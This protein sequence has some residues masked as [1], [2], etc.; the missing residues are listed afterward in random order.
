MPSK[1]I[2]TTSPAMAPKMGV[3]TANTLAVLYLLVVTLLSYGSALAPS[4]TFLPADLLLLRAPYKQHTAELSPGFHGV[5]RPATD[6]LFQFYPARK[7]LRDALHSGQVPLWNPYSL[8]GTPFAADDQSAVFYPI[9]WLFALIP[10]TMAFGWV[11]ALHTFLAGL[12]F[13]AWGRRLGWGHGAALSGAT[14]WMLSGVMVSW[15]MWQVVDSTLCWLPLALYFWEGYRERRRPAQAVGVSVA[16]GLCLLAGH[17][18]F[19]FFVWLT[20]FAYALYR[21]PLAPTMWTVAARTLW[22]FLLGAAL[23]FVQLAATADL[24]PR[25]VKRD[26]SLDEMLQTALPLKQLA[27]LVAPGLFGG[28][29]DDLLS[30]HFGAIRYD[31]GAMTVFG[32]PP[33]VGAVNLYE[34]TVY[35]GVAALVFAVCGMRLRDRGDLSRFWFGV[36]IFAL[37][38]GCGSPLYGLFYHYVPLFKSFHGVARVFA[39]FDFAIAAL[40]AAGIHRLASMDADARKRLALYAGGG[41]A[42]AMVIA[43]RLATTLQTPQGDVGSLLTHEWM[44]NGHVAR[45]FGVPLL[46]A[47]VAAVAVVQFPRMRKVVPLIIAADML[48]FA[49]GF[50]GGVS[51]KLLYPP[52]PETDFV[53]RNLGSGR[54]LCLADS[55]GNYQS[56][57]MPNSAMSIGWADVAGNDPL[58]LAS[59]D[60]FMRSINKAATGQEYPDGMGLISRYSDL[61]ANT[62]IKFVISPSP[63]DIPGYTLAYQGDLFIYRRLPSLGD[64]RIAPFMPP[65]WRDFDVNATSDIVNRYGTETIRVTGVDLYSA[66]MTDAIREP[67]WK[68]RIDGKPITP[69]QGSFDDVFGD[70][71]FIKVPLD[72][73]SHTVVLRY[74][75][76]PIKFGLYVT[77]FGCCVCAAILT[78]SVFRAVRKASNDVVS[79][80]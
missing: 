56:R 47:G 58:I 50:N 31:F 67:G 11:A 27:I 6:P 64:T 68:V 72:P 37:L 21:R 1:P 80:S 19:G 55:T 52:T 35:C 30:M 74:L 20:V 32:H 51:A 66:L 69:N 10:L 12:F 29:R 46:I 39:L 41:V 71:L 2:T 34:M 36:A 15:Q 8:S 48:L 24:L 65:T 26:A 45:F 73:G 14:A 40:C 43:L 28:Q 59:Y 23:S 17:L 79:G 38:M 4:N 49:V 13:W 25:A 62:G 44:A 76:T 75:P 57:L 77:L 9:N 7:Y 78:R 54:V 5:A 63:V 3:R 18:Q 60:R 53:S 16:L 33:F 42:F 70:N 22:P 61:L